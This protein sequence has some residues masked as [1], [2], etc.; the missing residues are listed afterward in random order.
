M[1]YWPIAQE[2]YPFMTFVLR[3]RGDATAVAAAVRNV[4]QTLD[5][6]Q[7][8]G[9]V[10]TL[11]SLVG[12][13]I[14]RQRFNT[15]LLAVFAVVALLLSAVGIYG[16]MSYVG[17]AAHP[18]SRHSRGPGRHRCRHP[19]AGAEARDEVDAAG[20]SR[21]SAGGGRVTRLIKNLLFGVGVTDPLTFVALPLLL[22]SVALL[23]CY[24]PARRAAKV[25]PMVAL[26]YE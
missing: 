5:P 1:S 13:S 6:Q 23:A 11:A 16:V 3:T 2:P 17:G 26:R 12:D 22:A 9:E 19:A 21:R 8:V 7:P 25:D 20:H 14:A 15:L 4:V 10:R 24:L 18:R